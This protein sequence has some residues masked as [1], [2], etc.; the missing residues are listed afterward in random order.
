[1]QKRTLARS[2]PRGSGDDVVDI[3]T[4]LQSTRDSILARLQ[5]E[6]LTGG[7]IVGVKGFD[8]QVTDGK[9][10]PTDTNGLIKPYYCVV[11]GGRG[12]AGYAQSGIVS[13]RAD[14]KRFNFG[15]EVYGVDSFEMNRFCDRIVDIL[16]GFEPDN[17]GEIHVGNSGEITN[18]ADVKQNHA[19]IGMGLL[20]NCY[21]GTISPDI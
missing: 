9:L 6:T 16:E 21:V 14:L 17:A 10:V 19:R 5:A 1:M 15:V 3:E 12:P 20:F 8:G 7:R 2:W 18:P 11:F 4:S 13:S